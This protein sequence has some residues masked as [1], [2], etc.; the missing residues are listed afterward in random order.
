MNMALDYDGTFTLAQSFWLNF[1]DRA[2]NEGHTV[3]IVTLRNGTIDSN[4][5]LWA[6]SKICPIIY[7]DGRAKQEVMEGQNIHID[8]WIDDLPGSIVLGGRMS[9]GELELWRK[10]HT[11]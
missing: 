8:I 1:I 9:E 4:N 6:L 2:Y 7:C 10:N 3:Y 11:D 5:E